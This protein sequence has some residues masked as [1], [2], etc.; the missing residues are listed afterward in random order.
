MP[1]R[2]RSKVQ[3]VVIAIKKFIAFLFS[4]VGLC[5]IVIAYTML[6]AVVFQAV[7]GPPEVETRKSQK[8]SRMKAVDFMWDATY[9][10]NILEPNLWLDK[11]KSSVYE[12]KQTL[13]STI[14]RGYDAKDA[15][16]TFSGAFLYSLTVI[17]TIGKVCLIIFF[18]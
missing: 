11:V 9:E 10:H 18:W 1:R 13:L 2:R 5:A 7:E 12:Y 14:R 3:R 4:H 6:G 15:Q 17:T 8:D 16:W